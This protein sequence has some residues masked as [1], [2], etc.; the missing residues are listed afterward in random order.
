MSLA[1][2]PAAIQLRGMPP[3]TDPQLTLSDAIDPNQ[4]GYIL[5]FGMTVV[6]TA[7]GHQLWPSSCQG[8]MPLSVTIC[9]P[10]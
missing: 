7:G 3:R 8:V 10:G 1:D 4:D 5:S 9:G 6:R 2:D